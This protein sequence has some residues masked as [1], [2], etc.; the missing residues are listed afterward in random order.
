LPKTKIVEVSRDAM[1]CCFSNFRHHFA[2][3]QQFA[4]DLGDLGRYYADG[5]N[6]M[7]HYR[8]VLPSTVHRVSY[9]AL[10]ENPERETR[11]LLT[12]LGLP[13]EDECLRFFESGRPV[14]SA[15]SEQVRQPL[16]RSGLEAWRNYEPWLDPLKNALGPFVAGRKEQ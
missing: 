8:E 11:A 9:E 1:A 3:G 16:F 14:R 15:S 4:Y 13:F 6:L 5:A 10:I 12:F 2:R 7:A